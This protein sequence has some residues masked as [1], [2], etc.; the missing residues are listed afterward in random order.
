MKG[1]IL[2]TAIVFLIGLS[3]LLLPL[4][5]QAESLQTPQGP[6]PVA[7]IL[8]RE[9]TLATKLVAVL[10]LG[11]ATS[12][13]QAESILGDKGIIP[14]NGW[15]ADYPVTPDVWGELYESVGDAADANKIPL[16]KPEALKR[17]ESVTSELSMIANPDN[18]GIAT[19]TGTEEAGNIPSS[20]VYDYY[21]AEGPPVVTYY[22]PPDDYY[23]LYSWVP[24]PFWYNRIGFG[25]YFI[26]NDFHRGVSDRRH[27]KG[28]I[29]NHFLN[30]S[31]QV[32]RVDPVARSS[33]GSV[34]GIGADA[35]QGFRVGIVPGNSGLN[36]A[37]VQTQ[38]TTFI[39][40]VPMTTHALSKSGSGSSGL[41][42]VHKTDVSPTSTYKPP[43]STYA[44]YSR[45]TNEAVTSHNNTSPAVNNTHGNYSSSHAS[46]VTA[47]AYHSSSGYNGGGF[48][49]RRVKR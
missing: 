4:F 5:S 39:K 35:G 18:S 26:L 32:V 49:G 36:S 23:S 22:P 21:N 29:S 2:K 1:L 45:S 41:P 28:F 27:H 34:A 33:G 10:N 31:N 24:Y 46:T 9:G 13:P 37:S 42:I 8:I 19:V 40:S 17:F 15:I 30:S 14:K 44:N 3:P 6:P 25:G 16:P 11:T 12:E 48:Y 43:V 20:N 47:P 38:T 7:Q